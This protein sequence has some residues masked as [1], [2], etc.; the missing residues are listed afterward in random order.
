MSAPRNQLRIDDAARSIQQGFVPLEFPLERYRGSPL[1]ER[2]RLAAQPRVS[3]SYWL[4]YRSRVTDR[5][6]RLKLEYLLR[7]RHFP[8]RAA[9]FVVY[10]VERGRVSRVHYI[11]PVVSLDPSSSCNLRCPGC[12]TGNATPGRR[13]RGFATLEAMSKVIDRIH[14]RSFQVQL[15]HWGEPLL[16]PSSLAASAYAA[17]RGLWTSIHS[18]LSLDQPNLAQRIVDSGL[19]NLV[20]SVDGATQKTYELYRRRGDVDLVFRNIEAI[21]EAR[22]SCGASLPWITAKFCVFDHNWHEVEAFREHAEQAGVDEV[23]FLGGFSNGVYHS[24]DIATELEFDLDTL[25]WSPRYLV[26][27]CRQL[28]E[29]MSID[30]DGAVYPCCD[31]FRDEDLFAPPES[32]WSVPLLDSWNSPSHQQSRRFFMGET[33]ADELPTPC[34]SCGRCV[35]SSSS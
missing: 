14:R 17:S 29:A 11:P 1:H 23:L 9:N 32:A 15:F 27:G 7:Q 2:A 35:G 18:N 20:V 10:L 21:V 22:N 3:D 5:Y 13:R 33:S 6:H 34:R 25:T 28:W 24:G 4:Q 16:S 12:T 31:A 26:P 30:Y 8:L 19:C